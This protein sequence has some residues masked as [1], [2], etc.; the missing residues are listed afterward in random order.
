MNEA[1][2]SGRPATL[3]LPIPLGQLMASLVQPLPAEATA[4]WEAE[5]DVF[6]LDE[7]LLQR[8]ATAFLNPPGGFGY[9]SYYP[10]R[11]AQGVLT[12]RQKTRIILWMNCH[13]KRLECVQLAGAVVRRGGFESGSKLHALQTL[14]AVRLRLCRAALVFPPARERV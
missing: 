11:P 9:P 1:K 8:P 2:L 10:G 3:A 12:A 5:D 6:V 4:G 14:R 7:P 13:A